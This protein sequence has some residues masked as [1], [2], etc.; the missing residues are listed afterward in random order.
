MASH[1]FIQKKSRDEM[2]KVWDVAKRVIES[3]GSLEERNK[4]P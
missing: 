3:F 2:A 1:R 4:I